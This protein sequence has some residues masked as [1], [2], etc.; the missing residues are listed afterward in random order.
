MANEILLVGEIHPKIEA[1]YKIFEIFYKTFENYK[2]HFREESEHLKRYVEAVP[3]VCST[4]LELIMRFKPQIVFM[5]VGV[6]RG[7]VK[8]IADLI[9]AE[10]LEFRYEGGDYRAA[11][12]K[13]LIKTANSVS[14]ITGVIGNSHLKPAKKALEGEGLDVNCVTAGGIM[15]KEKKRKIGE[16]FRIIRTMLNHRDL[17]YPC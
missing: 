13:Q 10:Y 6:G 2:N 9:N 7:D 12:I 16:A 15:D 17:S 11:L 1:E 4:E 8:D 14:R 5:E 3:T